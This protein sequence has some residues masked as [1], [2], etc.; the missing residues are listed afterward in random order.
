VILAGDVGGTKTHLALFTPGG[1]PRH[2]EREQLFAS[3]EHPSLESLTRA[4]MAGSPSPATRAVFG[5]AGVVIRNH[6]ETTNL[7]WHVDGAE[8]AEALGGARVTL[9]NDLAATAHGLEVLEGGDLETLQAGE[10]E[11]G[12]RAVL[13][14]GT[15]LGMVT[16]SRDGLRLVVAPSE[17]GHADWAPRT[18]LERELAAWLAERHGRA[19]VERVLSGRGLADLYRFLSATAR[20]AESPG[21]ADR[22]M[23]AEDP[24]ALVSEAALERSCERAELALGLF[25]DAY[26]AEAGNLALRALPG[27]GLFLGGGIAPRIRTALQSQRFLDAFRDKAPM[28]DL[29][30]RFPVQLILDSRAAL[31]GAAHLALDPS[32]RA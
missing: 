5:I 16:V 31:W 12:T 11:R 18:V 15:G 6:C 10:Q 7:P 25:V 27:E 4:F 30:R 9:L 24:A 14:A 32:A 19:S 21:F 26:G 20:G 17:G 1:S 3:H 28:T 23:T 29:L 8:L 2:P 22:F 13:A